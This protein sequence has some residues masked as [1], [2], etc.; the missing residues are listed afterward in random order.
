MKYPLI[1]AECECSHEFSANNQRWCYDLELVW[2]SISRWDTFSLCGFTLTFHV[3]INHT[4]TLLNERH[5]LSQY[6][7]KPKTQLI[8]WSIFFYFFYYE[9]HQSW[10]QVPFSQAK[11]LCQSGWAAR[12][13]Y[14]PLLFGR[15]GREGLSA[16]K[17]GAIAAITTNNWKHNYQVKPSGSGGGH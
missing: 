12:H 10:K 4:T 14:T 15:A 9:K 17:Q 3:Y 8:I 7:M 5:R 2:R 16:S 1:L 6:D 11:P 13:P